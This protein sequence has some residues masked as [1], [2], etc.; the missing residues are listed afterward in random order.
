MTLFAFAFAFVLV[1]F[2]CVAETEFLRLYAEE[3]GHA[4]D[5]TNAAKR[6]RVRCTSQACRA[7]ADD[8]LKQRRV[9]RRPKS[10][11]DLLA[12]ES[13]SGRT[14]AQAGRAARIR[15]NELQPEFRAQCRGEADSYIDRTR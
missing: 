6:A 1:A 5:P 13:R 10:F 4:Q 12:L 7:D 11:R 8:F 14:S 2:P 15:C 3:V 9:D